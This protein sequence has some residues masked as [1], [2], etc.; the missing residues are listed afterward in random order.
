MITDIMVLALSVP[1]VWRLQLGLKKKLL[2][3]GVFLVGI[4]YVCS[5]L[6][7]LSATALWV[8]T[9]ISAVVLTHI[10]AFASSPSFD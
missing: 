2:I 1:M 3:S 10:A 8:V 7:L 5:A 6:P 4:L 9:S